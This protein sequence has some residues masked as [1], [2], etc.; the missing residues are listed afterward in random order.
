V[1]YGELVSAYAAGFMV[2][3]N[4]SSCAEAAATTR[5]WRPAACACAG[6]TASAVGARGPPWQTHGRARW[7]RTLPLLASF[8]TGIVPVDGGFSAFNGV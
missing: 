2:Y 1:I 4:M 3:C 8:V 6:S 7:D 5:R